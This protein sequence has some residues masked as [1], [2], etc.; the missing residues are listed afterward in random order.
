VKSK[1]N[2]PHQYALGKHR[3]GTMSNLEHT[4][5]M[6]TRNTWIGAALSLSLLAG[7]GGVFA[8]QQDVYDEIAANTA[9]IRELELLEPLNIEVQDRDQLRDW[10]ITDIAES[11]PE[12]DQEADLRVL[13]IFGFIEPGT[14]LGDLQV[15]IL[16]EQIAGYYDP[17]TDQMVVVSTGGGE[18]LSASD[19][20]TFAHE[21]IH[22][23]QDQHFD[24]LAV[25]GDIDALSDDQSLAI[26]ALIEGDATTGQIEYLLDNPSLIRDLQDE[27]SGLD[28]SSLD[29]APQIYAETLLFPYEEG[30]D[31]VSEL[32]DEGG[33]DAV[34]AAFDNP[35]QSTEQVLH[36]DKY[37]AGEGPLPVTINDPLPALGDDWHVFDLNVMGEFITNVFLDSHDVDRGDAQQAAEGW[38]GDQYLVVGT[39]DETALVWKSAWDT[40]DD[41]QE[42]FAVLG[43]HELRRFETRPENSEQGVIQFE[44]DGFIGEIRLDGSDVLYVLAPGQATLDTLMQSQLEDGTIMTPP[45][46]DPST[47]AGA[48]R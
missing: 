38:G 5:P 28:S 24:L 13:V 42:F 23:L 39:E 12:V 32:H 25:Q 37:L 14:D 36:P 48:F 6:K 26:D 10:L 41:A 1:G 30:A 20:I 9:V 18:E 31:F 11:Y 27:L 47:P 44:G 40:E 43:R 22:A 45:A 34:N 4:P 21:T 8:A 17:E 29:D 35:P 2:Q 7:S 19:E 46:P 15:E 33:W 3:S 16:G